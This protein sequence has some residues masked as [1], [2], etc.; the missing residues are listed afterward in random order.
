MLLTAHPPP[1]L[2]NYFFFSFLIAILPKEFRSWP[3]A[4]Q[5]C[6]NLDVKMIEDS[7]TLHMCLVYSEA[8]WGIESPGAEVSDG[9]ELP[10]GFWELTPGPVQEQQVLL[11]AHPPPLLP[12]YFLFGVLAET[13]NQVIDIREVKTLKYQFLQCQD[14]LQARSISSWVNLEPPPPVKLLPCEDP[15]N[16]W[17][18]TKLERGLVIKF[19][20]AGY[21]SL[22]NSITY[23]EWIT[24]VGP[25][26][27]SLHW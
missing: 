6:S 13:N 4:V 8:R 5:R 27:Q 7:Q 14:F 25:V 22:S 10:L 1:L 15:T 11:A 12:S 18:K 3:Q 19:L 23:N 21:L 16:Y 17:L 20:S 2:P 9:S 24:D 26:P